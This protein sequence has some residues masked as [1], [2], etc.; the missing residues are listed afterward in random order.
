MP[1]CVSL[2]HISVSAC[3]DGD[4]ADDVGDGDDAHG[5]AVRA[6][7]HSRDVRGATSP[8]QFPRSPAYASSAGCAMRR[9]TG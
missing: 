6:H 1:L 8:T 5:G 3:G 4:G 7:A 2:D 9:S